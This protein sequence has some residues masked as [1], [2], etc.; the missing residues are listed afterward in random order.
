NK[1]FLPLNMQD[2]YVYTPADEARSTASYQGNNRPFAIDFLDNVYG[3][4]NI[5]STVH[6]LLKWDQALYP[7]KF[8]RQETLDSA[9]SPYSFERTGKKKNGFAWCMSIMKNVKKPLYHNDEKH[10]NN[11]VFILLSNAKATFIVLGNKFNRQIYSGKDI[12]NLFGDYE[13]S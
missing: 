9:F 2:T 12:C 10:S 4:K 3:D 13:D 8:F 6:D 11:T 1:F 7:G 5:Y